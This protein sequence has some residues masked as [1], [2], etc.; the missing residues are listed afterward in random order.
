ML[1]QKLMALELRLLPESA[2]EKLFIIIRMI[3]FIIRCSR[4][5][6]AMF[7]QLKIYFTFILITFQSVSDF[8]KFLIIILAN[9][10]KRKFQV[11]LLFTLFGDSWSIVYDD[12]Y[13]PPNS[14]L[15]I[16]SQIQFAVS[17][18]P[19]RLN[20]IRATSFFQMILS[21]IAS[22]Q[23]SGGLSKLVFSQH[24]AIKF[25]QNLAI[26]QFVVKSNANKITPQLSVS[27]G[28]WARLVRNNSGKI[29]EIEWLIL[30]IK[31]HRQKKGELIFARWWAVRRRRLMRNLFPFCLPA[32]YQKQR[33]ENLHELF[34]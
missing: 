31:V 6:T 13:F 3:T 22:T 26:S 8:W 30:T 21:R 14:D 29:C 18:L 9:S 7:R 28:R 10:K 11:L 1:Q 19:Y 23:T 16:N 5:A 27:A 20:G 24:F 33:S 32:N 17:Q 15:F 2:I 34:E 25:G 4:S 12:Y